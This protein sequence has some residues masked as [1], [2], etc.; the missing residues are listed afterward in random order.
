MVGGRFWEGGS[1]R[2]AVLFLA[3]VVPPAVA[4]IWSGL[5]LIDQDRELWVQREEERRR[6][7]KQAAVL[8]L[9]QSLAEAERQFAEGPLPEG[10]VRFRLSA[11]GVQVDPPDRVLWV[12][13]PIP[14]QAVPG[15]PFAK[16]EALEYR[17][18]TAQARLRYEDLVRS[19]QPGVRAGALLRLARV[20][21]QEE[22][23]QDALRAYR[24]LAEIRGMAFDGMPADLLARRAACSVL[25]ES[26]SRQELTREA[27]ALESEFV[28]GRWILDP[29]SWELA[30]TQIGQWSGR[31][32]SLSAERGAFSQAAQWLWDDWQRRDDHSLTQQNRRIV[33]GDQVPITLLRRTAG[34]EGVA[35]G[36][37]PPILRSW[38]QRAGEGVTLVTE[39]GA[40][41]A[42]LKPAPG[43][44]V[45]KLA[46][47]AT[48][49]PWIL[50]LSPDDSRLQKQQSAGRQRLLSMGLAAIVLFLAGGS[51]LVWRVVRRELAVAR[52]QTEFVATV[53]HEFR[54]PLTSLRHVTELLEEDDE[55]PRE[56]R[57]SFYQTLG[58]NTARL[59]RL[60]ES[61]LD[62]ARMESGRRPYDLKPMQVGDFARQVAEDFRKEAEPLGFKIIFEAEPEGSWMVRADAASLANA[63]WNLLD[64]AV[65]YSPEPNS[66]RI[67]VGRHRK[68][69]ALSVQDHGLGIPLHERREIFCKFVRGES[70]RKLGIK[71][72]GLGLAKVT[73]IV[74]AHGGAI[75]LE[76][77]EGAGST[78]RIVLPAEEASWPAY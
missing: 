55:L 63:L 60:V 76:S 53:S 21:R 2:L 5:E 14:M 52:L 28:A 33:V 27:A 41:L 59:H 22:R 57:L 24:D 30:A 13:A 75:E 3:V 51:F 47:S 67:A 29:S 20:A 42:G 35:V 36:L 78:F 68:G 26:G 15:Q 65:K 64:N 40:I 10:A 39:S 48:G 50:I 25:E 16:A 71:G 45:A 32:L 8:S 54:T 58:R 1:R 37:A 4:L 74:E 18:A 49:L 62:F 61:L 7:A 69:V 77:E 31:A 66:I 72:T 56:R 34:G 19:S 17:G 6:T 23:W 73:H 12:P 11:S 43:P 46:P 9:E 44:A 70:A 38:A